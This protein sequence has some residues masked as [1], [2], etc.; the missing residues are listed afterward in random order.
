MNDVIM[1]ISDLYTLYVTSNQ[2]CLL[3][4]VYEHLNN[5]MHV[6][7]PLQSIYKCFFISKDS[8]N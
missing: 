3:Y 8:I 6:Y 7:I 2:N 5:I 1:H 4:N